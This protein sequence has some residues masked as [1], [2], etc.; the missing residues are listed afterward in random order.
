MMIGLDFTN[1]KVKTSEILVFRGL[2]PQVKAT[3]R[4]SNRTSKQ[5]TTSDLLM[6]RLQLSSYSHFFFL[7]KIRLPITISRL[8]TMTAG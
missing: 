3:A 2:Q 6:A 4:Q 1:K 8:T 5:P 7:K